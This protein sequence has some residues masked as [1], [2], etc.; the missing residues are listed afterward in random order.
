MKIFLQSFILISVVVLILFILGWWK[1]QT[2]SIPSRIK[3]YTTLALD[4]I[5]FQATNFYYWITGQDT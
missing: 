2:Y 1:W 4:T 3:Y 5:N